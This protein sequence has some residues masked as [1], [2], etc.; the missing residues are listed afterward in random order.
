MHPLSLRE[1]VDAKWPGSFHDFTGDPARLAELIDQPELCEIESLV[2]C[3]LQRSIRAD[4][5]RER[6]AGESGISPER[7]LELYRASCTIYL[8]RLATDP[9]KRWN[10]ALDECFRLI[11]GTAQINAFASTAGRG[12]S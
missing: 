5:T 9:V 2:R 12:L 3:P 8:S 7:A 11:P 6:R 4:Y 1:F 10:R